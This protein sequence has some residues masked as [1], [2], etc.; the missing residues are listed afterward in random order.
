[1]VSL[2]TD[3]AISSVEVS[4]KKRIWC[5]EN[6]I[7]GVQR[8]GRSW[9]IPKTAEKP[10]DLRRKRYHICLEGDVFPMTLLIKEL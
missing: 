3:I 4:N 10:K 2:F 9:M 6:R 8:F 5:E 1:M 7:K